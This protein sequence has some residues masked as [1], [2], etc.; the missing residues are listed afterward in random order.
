MK[1]SEWLNNENNLW[2]FYQ[3]EPNELHSPRLVLLEYVKTCLWT[4]YIFGKHNIVN[5]VLKEL[6][7]HE[8]RKITFL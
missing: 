7:I 4:L 2:G 6:G 8:N 3:L 5:I 1:V